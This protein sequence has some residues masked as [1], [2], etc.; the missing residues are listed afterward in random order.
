MD[1]LTV[2]L[3]ALAGFLAGAF[4]GY[5]VR[6][7]GLPELPRLLFRKRERRRYIVFEALTSERLGREEVGRAF[8]LAMKELY[9]ELGLIASR[10]KLIE[11]DEE[12]RRGAVRVR[13][14]YKDH[15]LAALAYVREVEGK[16]ARLVP[17][18]ATGSLRRARKLIF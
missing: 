17:I 14:S 12:R 1:L 3:G 5:A 9:G 10:A 6:R 18:A 4:G 7:V 8:A 2:A 13:S 16:K 11:Y 15:A